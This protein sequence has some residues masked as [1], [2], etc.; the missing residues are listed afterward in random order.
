MIERFVV[1]GLSSPRLP[2]PSP[3]SF[4]QYFFSPFSTLQIKL[5]KSTQAQLPFIHMLTV[6]VAREASGRE[7]GVVG[8]ALHILKRSA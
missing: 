2:G 1:F 4:E 7:G 5:G 3:S 6:G 8:H